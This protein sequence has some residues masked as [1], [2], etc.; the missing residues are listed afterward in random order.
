MG[1]T[2]FRIFFPDGPSEGLRLLEKSNWTGHGVFCPRPVFAEA[3]SR[4]EFA[5]TGI[6][7]L[8]GPSG[9]GELPE[10]YI[11][12]GDPIRP[13]LE[14]H[15]RNLDFWTTA[16]CFTSKDANLN[17]AH[18]QYLE[19]RLVDLAQGAKR[20]SLQNGN[21]PQ[22]PSLSEADVADTE[23]FLAEMLLCFPVLGV[24][25]F[26]KP[27]NR[28]R[29]R[30]TLV[31]K[32]KG[33]D[34]S[35]YESPGGF[36][37]LAGSGVVEQEVPSIHAYITELRASLLSQGVVAEGSSGLVFKQDYEF[38]SP[39]TAASVV[40]ARTANGRTNWKDAKGRTLKEIQELSA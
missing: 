35:G 24:S 32:S 26:E 39:S 10:V 28:S 16:I 11:G 4:G 29:M 27:D 3:K 30:E 18:V 22:L 40:L 1:G 34:A 36:V 6:Y 33:V 25:V 12:E 20:C 14:S 8:L 37:V 7:V 19:S 38:K 23:A 5:R 15:Q 9:E 21:A 17:K 2:S 13:R 31:I